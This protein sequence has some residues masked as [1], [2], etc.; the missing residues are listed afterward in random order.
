MK[1]NSPGGMHQ[2]YNTNTRLGKITRKPPRENIAAIIDSTPCSAT[3]VPSAIGLVKRKP[4]RS[5]GMVSDAHL[6]FVGA[7]SLL[8]EAPGPVEI[9][10]DVS[11]GGKPTQVGPSDSL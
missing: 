9:A 2:N 8:C 10:S 4:E 1:N 3:A 5:S 7:P 11:N 6:V